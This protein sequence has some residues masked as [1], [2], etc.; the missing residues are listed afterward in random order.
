M[1]RSEYEQFKKAC[2][3]DLDKTR[4]YFQDMENTPGYRWGYGKLRRRGTLF[5]RQNQ[6]NMPY[7]QGVFLDIFP[8]DGV[9]DEPCLRKLHKC[10]CF[11]VR[12]ILW[13]AVGRIADEKRVM[14]IWYG[15]LYHLFG[16][17]IY[18]WYRHLVKKS[19]QKSTELVRALTFP[20]PHNA[21]GYKREWYCE[22]TEL[23][24][25]NHLF[26]VESGYKQWLEQE[27]G[28]YMQLPPEEERKVHPVSD[29]KLIY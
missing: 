12:K 25:E 8:R 16:D 18:S 10:E 11:C 6:E 21:D 7:E 13:S 15:F 22:Y 26:M 24:F 3:E 17:K 4:F 27:F 23:T 5:L 28:D 1:M 9:P 19:N 20:V 14:R 2:E 29:I